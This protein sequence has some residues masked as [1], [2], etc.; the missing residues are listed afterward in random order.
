MS[1]FLPSNLLGTST[2]SICG[3][4]DGEYILEVHIRD[5]FTEGFSVD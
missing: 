4:L 5:E 1:K 3:D 2:D